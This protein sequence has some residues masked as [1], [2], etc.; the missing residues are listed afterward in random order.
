[1]KILR[2]LMS[3]L[4]MLGIVTFGLSTAYAAMHP[5][6]NYQGRLT[7]KQ[8]KPL[9]ETYNIKLKI[10]DV[11]TGDGTIAWEEK[12]DNV[13]IQKG[14]FSVVLGSKTPLD[15]LAFDRAY[16]LEVAVCKAGTDNYEI[17]TP[18]QQI[19]WAAYAIRAE[20]TDK[21]KDSDTVSGIAASVAPAPNKLLPLD[22]KAKLP[23]SA[24]KV[25]DSGWFAVEANK[26]YQLGH[27]LNT[28]KL[29]VQL[30]FSNSSNG[31]NAA[32]VNMDQ[33]ISHNQGVSGLQYGASIYEITNSS[34]TI[35]TGSNDVVYILPSTFYRTGYYRV[36]AIALE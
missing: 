13:S 33:N 21:A 6:I 8:G 28:N 2:I 30:Y 31:S 20:K 1:M 29:I 4:F 3:A 23:L 27:S 24:L 34:L 25:Y 19:A 14:I 9:D 16:Y 15:D 5:L 12:H 26:R 22:D 35:Y 17:M 11:L 7:D 18:R 32:I 10:Y 36:I